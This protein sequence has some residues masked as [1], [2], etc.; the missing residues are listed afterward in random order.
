MTI[1]LSD[2]AVMFTCDTSPVSKMVQAMSINVI[3]NY[4]RAGDLKHSASF[5]SQSLLLTSTIVTLNLEYD[6]HKI[7]MDVTVR[8]PDTFVHIVYQ[9]F[10]SFYC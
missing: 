10:I 9:V 4:L 6:V 2:P 5:N 1:P 3:A 7:Y 8:C